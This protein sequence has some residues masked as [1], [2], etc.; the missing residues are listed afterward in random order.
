LGLEFLISPAIGIAKDVAATLWR[1][2]RRPDPTALIE[3][4]Q[5]LKTDVESHLRWIDNSGRYGEAIVRDIKRVDQ[6][7]NIDSKSK[8][9]S[10]WFK[11][12]L[13]GTYHR[14]LLVGLSFY[15][16]KRCSEEESWHITSDYKSSDMNAILVGRIPYDRI[17][18]ID[19]EGDEYYGSPH[20]YCRFLGWRPSPYEELIFC[21]E[22]IS[23]YPRPHNWYTELVSYP[24]A[25]TLTKR[26]EPSYFA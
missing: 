20:V 5:K 14:G 4:R 13:L 2:V 23:D 1:K 8:G 17:V 19:W 11:T 21:E 9:I 16:L 26:Y 7:P 3:R 25:K 6:Y 15:S 18:V 24:K 10:A 22:H 12:T